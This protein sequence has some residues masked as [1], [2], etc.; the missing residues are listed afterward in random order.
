MRA[1]ARAELL[2]ALRE[3]Y[4]GSW[5]RHVG[6]DGGKTLAWKGKVGLIFCSTQAFDD[7]RALIASLGDRFLVCRLPPASGGQLKKALAHT[8][9]TIKIMRDEL[10]AAVAGLFAGVAGRE[11]RP[12]SDDEITRL[13][14]VVS[15]AVR[16]RGHVQRDRYS[17]EIESIHDPEGQ[18]RIGLCL[19]RLL[20]G[21]DVIGLDR[22]KAMDLIE[23]IALELTP[24]IRRQA[25]ALLE[26]PAEGYARDRHGAQAADHHRSPDAAG[27]GRATARAALPRRQKERREEA[28][29]EGRSRIRKSKPGPKRSTAGPTCGLVTRN[30]RGFRGKSNRRRAAHRRNRQ[31]FLRKA[32]R[33]RAAIRRRTADLLRK[34]NRRPI[35][36][37]SF[38]LNLSK[39]RGKVL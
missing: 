24:L 4:D 27:S 29:R 34:S 17:R 9:A 12:I 39:G 26:R 33:R 31:G 21:L 10:A 2:A 3:I 1:E 36:K 7:E 16:L 32:I 20:A 19:E 14:N 8:G 28:R 23:G 13:E 6:A 38:P 5:T 11:P 25:F 30:R 37:N 35:S 18:A 15:L 22:D